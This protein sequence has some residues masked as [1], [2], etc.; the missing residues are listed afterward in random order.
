MAEM[1]HEFD[2]LKGMQVAEIVRDAINK[3][4]SMSDRSMYARDNKIGVS[5][6]GTCRE[7]VRRT[8]VGE[9]W[10]DEQDNF[11]AAFTGTAVGMLGE[12]AVAKYIPGA[13]VQIPV[14]V[15]LTVR[16]F[17][18][19]LPGHADV[20]ISRADATLLEHHSA[21][22][23]TG[24]D[25]MGCNC[26]AVKNAHDELWDFKTKD[27]L[28]VVKRTGPTLQQMFQVTMYAKA[29]IDE[30]RL[31]QEGLTLSLV[32]IDRSGAEPEP[33]VFSFAYDEQVLAACIEWID[34]VIYAVENDEQASKDMPRN[35]C[36]SSCPRVT[37]CR[38]GDTDVSG[39]IEDPI[40]KEAVKV[41]LESG[42]TIK[43]ATKD[44]ESAKSALVGVAGSTGEHIIR[45]V[46]V[47]ETEIAATTRRGYSRIGITPIKKGK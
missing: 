10:S 42:A 43:A 8:I 18:L 38:G 32:F 15:H 35:W 22:E 27:G 16:G 46:D 3:S 2:S 19:H 34:D 14:V 37:A 47:P 17:E 25:G 36:E 21:C 28:G 20:M 9:P 33:F 11:A 7:Y 12:M 44:K 41:Y 30:G 45:W 24:P 39:L 6:I 26:G 13:E 1:I 29:L 4:M 31:R 23:N 40:V 5:D